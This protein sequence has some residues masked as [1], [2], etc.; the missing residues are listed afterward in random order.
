MRTAAILLCVGLALVG[1]AGP[2]SAAGRVQGAIADHYQTL[3]GPSGFLGAPTTDEVTTPNGVGRYNH[4]EH[5]GSIYW[6]PGSGAWSIHGAIRAEWAALNWEAGPLGFPIT[7]EQGT[8]NGLARYNHLQGGS[9]YWSPNTGA[10]ETQGAIEASWQSLGWEAGF[11]GL[12][13]TDETET[14]NGAGRYNHFQGGSVYW[15]PANGAHEGHGAIRD[16]WARQGWEAGGLGFPT[17]DEYAVPGGRASSFQGGTLRFSFA[18]GQA[19]QDGA[20]QLPIAYNGSAN[21]VLTVVAAPGSS[22]ATLQAWR[23]ISGGWASVVGPVPAKVGPTGI[24]QASESSAN[25]PAGTYSLTQAFGRQSNPGTALPYFQTGWQDWWDENPSSPTY[26]LHVVQSQSPGGNSENLYDAGPVYDEAVVI[27]Y[28]TARVPGAGSG[29][30]LHVTN[31]SPTAGCVAIT[32]PDLVAVMQ[33]L[34]PGQHPD[35]DIATR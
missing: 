26:N 1:A 19:T 31:G 6:S 28:N 35:I 17:T 7:D 9:I 33:F 11:L 21:Q 10:H 23:R 5:N 15:S 29:F 8:P 2:A 34:T 27:D 3:G 30:F 22:N 16:A 32:Q 14:P 20:Q 18:T 24:G 25:T 13:V 4:F 12:P